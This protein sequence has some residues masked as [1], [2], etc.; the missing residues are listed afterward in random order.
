MIAM[1][2]N[3]STSVKARLVFLD[4]FHWFFIN[5]TPSIRNKNSFV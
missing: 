1:T 5:S 2:T 3:N 4:Q